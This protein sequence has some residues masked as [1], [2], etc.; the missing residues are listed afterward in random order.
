MEAINF[1]SRILAIPLLL[2]VLVYQKTLSPDHGMLRPWFPYGYC[3]FHPS[4]SEYAVIV[5]RRQGIVGLYKIIYR[6]IKCRPGV[7]PAVDNP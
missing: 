7:A 3:K 4:C 2:L 5:L 6:L 1:I